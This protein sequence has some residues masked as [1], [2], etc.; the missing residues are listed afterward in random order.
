MHV[1]SANNPKVVEEVLGLAQYVGG[2]C[3][4]KNIKVDVR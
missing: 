3:S 1:L 4:T 2:G